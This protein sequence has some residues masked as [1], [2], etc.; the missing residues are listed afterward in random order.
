[1]RVLVVFVLHSL[2]GLNLL[3]LLHNRALIGR[4]ARLLKYKTSFINERNREK[5]TQSRGVLQQIRYILLR[6][7][8][9]KQLWMVKTYIEKGRLRQIFEQ[10]YYLDLRT[11]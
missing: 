6:P 10:I 3:R 2:G 9:W 5:G 4:N 1:M 11:N 7:V 8:I